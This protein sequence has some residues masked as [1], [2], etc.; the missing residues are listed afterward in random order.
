[1]VAGTVASTAAV[2]VVAA[3]RLCVDSSRGSDCGSD[4]N[5]LRGCIRNL[6]APKIG[7]TICVSVC[8]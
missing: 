8:M 4:V 3:S 1:M 2:V 6:H 5:S 7:L